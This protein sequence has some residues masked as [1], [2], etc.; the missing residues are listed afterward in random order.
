MHAFLLQPL[1]LMPMRGINGAAFS[2]G[3]LPTPFPPVAPARGT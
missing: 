2:G 1:P 3:G